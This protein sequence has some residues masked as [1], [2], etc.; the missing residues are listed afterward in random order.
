MH[1]FVSC[2]RLCLASVAVLALAG[3]AFDPEASITRAVYGSDAGE[4]AVVDGYPSSPSTRRDRLLGRARGGPGRLRR[5]PAAVAD[6]DGPYLLD[7]G[8][9]LRV[10]VY[11]QPNLSRAYT[12]DHDGRITVPADRRRG[13]ARAHHRRA[14]SNAIRHRLASEFVRDPQVTVDIL[15]NR[16]FFI[17][18][19]V[20]TAGQYPYVSGMTVETAIAIAG[21]YSERASDRSVPHHAPHERLRRADRGAERLRGPARRHGLC[22]RA[23]L[24]G[25][26]RRERTRASTAATAYSTVMRA[27]VGGLFRHVMDLAREQ[28]ARGHAVGIIADK[29]AADASDRRTA[30]ASIEPALKLGLHLVPMGRQ[31]GFERC[32]RCDFGHASRAGAQGRHPAWSWR[33]GRRLCAPRRARSQIPGCESGRLLHT[34]RRQSSL[35]AGH[36][37]RS[38]LHRHRETSQIAAPTASYSRAISR[39]APMP[40]ASASAPF[41]RASFANGLL[42]QDFVAHKPAVT[43]PTSCSSASCG[44]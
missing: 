22:P 24:L 8:D 41:R 38:D 19:E 23:F 4:V 11:G 3:C 18:G 35:P 29:S 28:K 17:L 7:T 30:C 16:P 21:G 5:R 20:K 6:T 25:R 33:Q 27:P 31:P 43:P 37:F 12:V 2:L 36:A 15:Q 40:N 1:A 34:A 39:A 13:R 32:D 42:H 9:R 44:Y 14:S 10:F 26:A